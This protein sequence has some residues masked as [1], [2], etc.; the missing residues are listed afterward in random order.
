MKQNGFTLIEVMIALAI[1]G[2]SLGVFMSI[3]GNSLRTR[4]KLEDH[5]KNVITARITAEKMGLGLLEDNME[6]ETENETHWEVTPVSVAKRLKN[7]DG[8]ESPFMSKPDYEDMNKL[9]Y[10]ELS[11]PEGQKDQTLEKT[12]FYN[13][14]VG[15]IELNAAG[16]GVRE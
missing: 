15:G 3:L 2:A 6:G 7:E 14:V 5:A 9:I 4:W 11:I 16:K 13:V 10:E 8:I 1:V 12:G